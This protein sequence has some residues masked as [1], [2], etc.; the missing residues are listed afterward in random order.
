MPDLYTAIRDDHDEHRALLSSI[1][2]TWE[3]PARR[4]AWV[5]FYTEVK[6]HTV[7]EEEALYSR[8]LAATEDSTARETAREH[9]ALDALMEELNGTEMNSL[10]WATKFKKLQEDYLHHIE[11]EEHDI[12]PRARREIPAGE[13]G[14]AGDQFVQRKAEARRL[15]MPARRGDLEEL[16]D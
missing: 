13:I 14:V 4:K 9:E 15:A 8:L 12:F 16:E 6:S 11:A 3:D 5:R 1:A 2:D 7:A 10:A